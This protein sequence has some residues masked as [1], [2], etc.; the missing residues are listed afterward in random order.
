[1]RKEKLLDYEFIDVGI[2]IKAIIKVCDI[3]IFYFNCHTKYEETAEEI[4][5][6]VFEKALNP[7]LTNACKELGNTIYPLKEIEK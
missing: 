7:L 4:L 1:M 6:E 2:N 5:S 3:P